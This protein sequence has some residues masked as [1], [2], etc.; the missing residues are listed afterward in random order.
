[1]PAGLVQHQRREVE[2][3]RLATDQIVGGG[4]DG[5]LVRLPPPVQPFEPGG[6]DP[7][8]PAVARG[9]QLHRLRRVIQPP[10][11][12]Q[13]RSELKAD[14]L[15]GQVGQIDAGL[16]SERPQAQTL[17]RP[18]AFQPKLEQIARIAPLLGHIGD[19][20]QRHQIE[21]ALKLRR[22]PAQPRIQR[23]NQFVG[24]ANAR[25][26][27]QRVVGRQTPGVE[28]GGRRE[29]TIGR[30]V[31]MIGDDNPDA[32]RGGIGDCIVSGDPGVATE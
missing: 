27:G 12:I 31:V 1:M 29:A 26:C 10:G 19:D 17:R 24:H 2:Q 8:L 15:C 25:K 18:Q 4:R 20:A 23:L 21:Q 14:A 9:Q 6:N 30:Q 22:V 13:A 32:L 11:G 7:G 16:L 5:P 28:Y 3:L